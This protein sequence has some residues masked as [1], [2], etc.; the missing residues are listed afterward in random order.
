MS[1]SPPTRLTPALVLNEQRRIF[2]Q[3]CAERFEGGRQI[4]RAEIDALVHLADRVGKDMAA[5]SDAAMRLD[6]SLSRSFDPRRA[7][8]LV[9]ES[10]FDEVLTPEAWRLLASFLERVSSCPSTEP[11]AGRWSPIMER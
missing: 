4:A 9:L 5:W 1:L 11:W 10:V 3:A 2:E 7:A 8:V 6:V